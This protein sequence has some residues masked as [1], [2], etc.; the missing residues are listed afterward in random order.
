MLEIGI[1]E[2]FILVSTARPFICVRYTLGSIFS[3]TIATA[4]KTTWN[5]R[6]I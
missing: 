2:R 4:I 3:N 5:K 1:C 6:I